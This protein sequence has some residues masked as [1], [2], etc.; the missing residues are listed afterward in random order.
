MIQWREAT[1]ER[2]RARWSGATELDVVLAGPEGRALPALAYSDLVG[3]PQPGDRVLLNVAALELG[4]GTGGMALVVAIPDRLPAD[5]QPS[6]GHIVKARYTPLQ[7]VV[8]GVDEQES[9]HHEILS[10]ASGIEGMPVIVADLHSAVP[11]ILAGLREAEPGARVAYV[12]TDGGALPMAFSRTV[13]GLQDAGWLAGTITVG[14]AFGGDLEAVNV[15]TG[16]LAAALVLHADAAIVAQ[17]PG[18]L[19]TDSEWGYSGVAAGETVNAVAV[20]GGRAVASLRVSQADPRDR[21]RGISHHSLTAYGRVA[22][23]PADLPVPLL[24]GDFGERVLQQARE[25]VLECGGRLSL[26]EVETVGLVGALAS[27]PV[28][29][30]TMGRG[31]D[32]D[33]ASFVAAAAAGRFAATLLSH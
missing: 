2:V 17:G 26:Q 8:L 16:L 4:L 5:P 9:P 18:N 33:E 24:G 19:G 23:A 31:L 13:A 30:C 28:S 14:Q 10:D 12:M 27:S 3:E 32:Q 25:L 21:H 1:V 29:L 15:H 7:T 22:M 11:A 6:P 20:L